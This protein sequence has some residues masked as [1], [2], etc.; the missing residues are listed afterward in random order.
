MEPVNIN[1]S[2]EP[3]VGP[4][5]SGRPVRASKPMRQRKAKERGTPPDLMLVISAI[6]VT[7]LMVLAGTFAVSAII[8]SAKN[9]CEHANSSS[10][11]PGVSTGYDVPIF[12]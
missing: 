5:Q 6:A 2:E 3:N 7:V 4:V 11:R 8:G 10:C 9:A 1:K 12:P